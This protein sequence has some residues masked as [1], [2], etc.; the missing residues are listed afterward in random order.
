MSLN[1]EEVA[2]RIGEIA[3][4]EI[5]SR[6]GDLAPE[7]VREKSGPQDLVT[8]VDEAAEAALRIALHDLRPDAAF[9]GEEAAAR[10]QSIA[11]AI[12]RADA[13]WIVDPLDGTRN[14]IRGVREFG[15][16]VA[17]VEKG[18]ARMG[19]IYAAPD[20]QCAIAV[21]GG[22]ASC[23]GVQIATK[24]PAPGQLRCL[25]SLGWL[26]H[27]RQDLM[28]AR[29]AEEFQSAPGHCSAYAYLKLAR[30]E[31][32]LKLSSRIH[33]WDHVA[34]ALLTAELGGRTAFLDSGADYAPQESIDA[35]LLATAPGR[36]W[37]G[38]AA[39]IR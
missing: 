31:I 5:L 16:I 21:A 18:R 4:R 6:F 17:L 37:T 26:P 10:D 38:I 25:R 9:V 8:A 39:R 33:P 12:A 30:G 13:V 29:L 23:D 22:G 11:Q 36:D 1:P 35:P 2:E 14:F 7:D 28:R 20:R 32:D 24:P 19:W 3:E 27:P 34:G 15:V